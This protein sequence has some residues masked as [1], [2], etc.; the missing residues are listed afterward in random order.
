MSHCFNGITRSPLALTVKPLTHT[1]KHTQQGFDWPALNCYFSAST[2]QHRGANAFREEVTPVVYVQSRRRRH[3]YFRLI[4]RGGICSPSVSLQSFFST[5]CSQ[6]DIFHGQPL[7]LG[8]GF[9]PCCSTQGQ[10][11][12]EYEITLYNAWARFKLKG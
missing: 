5:V 8:A 7:C 12:T 6:Q 3:F 11:D 4:L 10:F 9:R 1:L 2:L